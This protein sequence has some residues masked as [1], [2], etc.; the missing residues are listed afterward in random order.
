MREEIKNLKL[1]LAAADIDLDPN[2][3]QGNLKNLIQPPTK[4]NFEDFFT[5][6]HETAVVDNQVKSFR[7]FLQTITGGSGDR[8][9]SPVSKSR[10]SSKTRSAVIGSSTSSSST[11]SSSFVPVSKQLKKVGVFRLIQVILLSK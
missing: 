4:E 3:C 11:M 6:A 9:K 7:S 5:I 2:L 8:K 1:R 10:S